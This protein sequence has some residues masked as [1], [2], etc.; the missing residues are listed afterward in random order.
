MKQLTHVTVI[1]NPNSTGNGYA[2]AKQLKKELPSDTY[3]VHLVAT[4]YAGHAEEIA[5]NITQ[6]NSPHIIISSS[7]DGGYNEVINGV[8]SQAQHDHIIT[9]VLPSGNANDHYHALENNDD[10][11]KAI[12][13]RSF[14]TIDVLELITQDLQRYAHSY[15]G[16]GVTAQIGKKLTEA[17]LNPFNEIWIVFKNLFTV[18]PVKIRWQG[19]TTR[20]DNLLFSNVGTMSKVLKISQDAS[21]YD[22]KFEITTQKTRSIGTLF[23]HL[24]HASTFG[25]NGTKKRSQ[26][27]FTVR[28]SAAAQLDGE[29][30]R[31][32]A[33]TDVT[34]R[35]FKQALR[36][37]G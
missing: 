2:N 17:T 13:K 9:G 5:R 12:K 31:I 10:V 14:T 11:A 4:K 37:I 23:A 33:K 20:Y 30:V 22:G 8:L 32:P 18:R 16:F 24:L 7:G 6:K 29:V 1:Y 28:R 27:T 3:S 34:I 15:I 19:R 21:L 36:C 25:L 26:V 35:I